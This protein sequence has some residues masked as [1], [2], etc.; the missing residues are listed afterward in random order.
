M[1]FVH[2]D[3]VESKLVRVFHFIEVAGIERVALDR[4]VERIRQQDGDR[5][6]F[7]GSRKIERA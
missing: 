4:I 3:A 7:C 1:M 2:A 6:V 5:F